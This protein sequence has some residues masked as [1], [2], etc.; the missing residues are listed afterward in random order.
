MVLCAAVG[1]LARFFLAR[2][3]VRQLDKERPLPEELRCRDISV[4]VHA[5]T[6]A[7]RSGPV[8]AGCRLRQGRQPAVSVQQGRRALR[9][10]WRAEHGGFGATV[11]L[12]QKQLPHAVLRSAVG[13]QTKEIAQLGV[14]TVDGSQQGES[15]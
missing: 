1:T 14:F 4:S 13:L 11:L 3:A 10:N 6:R 8:L 5:G 7:R 15:G 2:D 12:R 9:Y